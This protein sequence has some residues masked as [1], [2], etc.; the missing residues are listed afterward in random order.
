MPRSQLG[1]AMFEGALQM[2]ASTLA[3]PAAVG[4][5]FKPLKVAIIAL[6]AFAAGLGVATLVPRTDTATAPA[7]AFNRNAFVLDE[8]NAGAPAPVFNRNAFILEEHNS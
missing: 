4:L 5:R 8:H 7:P 6:A 1:I 2:T 3:Q